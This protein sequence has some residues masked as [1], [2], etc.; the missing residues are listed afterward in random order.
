MS[1]FA[2]R[3]WCLLLSVTPLNGKAGQI[4]VK[5]LARI[6]NHEMVIRIAEW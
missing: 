2:G 1:I 5:E 3:N 6:V 4:A